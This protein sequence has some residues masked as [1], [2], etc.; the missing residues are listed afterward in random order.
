MTP[1][2]FGRRI[3]ASLDA[4]HKRLVESELT[5]LNRPAR[6]PLNTCLDVSLVESLL[7]RKQPTLDEDLAAIL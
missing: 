2:E 6:R 7:D 3:A 1:F 4:S 5:A